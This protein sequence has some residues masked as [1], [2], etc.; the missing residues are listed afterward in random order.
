MNTLFVFSPMPVYP[1]KQGNRIRLY[2]TLK[3]FIDQGYRITFFCNNLEDSGHIDDLSIAMHNKLFHKFIYT[4]YQGNHFKT[5]ALGNQSEDE[6]WDSTVVELLKKEISLENF[7]ICITNYSLF[8]KVF[9]YFPK[10]THKI[11]EMHDRLG[12]RAELVNSNGIISDFF[13]TNIEREIKYLER[14]DTVICIKDAE[15]KY[16]KNNGFTKNAVTGYCPLEDHDAF[17]LNEDYLYHNKSLGFIGSDNRVNRQCISSIYRSINKN[18]EFIQKN[19][20]KI[21]I[22]GKISKFAESILPTE[23]SKNIEILG[24]IDEISDFYKK[25]SIL[26]NPT[27]FS[28]GFKLKNVESFSFGVPLVSTQDASDG[29]PNPPTFLKNK[30]PEATIVCAIKYLETSQTYSNL[31]KNTLAI[32]NKYRAIVESSWEKI[33]QIVSARNVC[34]SIAQELDTNY[35]LIICQILSDYIK[36]TDKILITDK[37]FNKI[38]FNYLKFNNFIVRTVKFESLTDIDLSLSINSVQKPNARL[39]I[40]KKSVTISPEV[41]DKIYLNITTNDINDAG[42]TV[43]VNDVRPYYIRQFNTYNSKK[44]VIYFKTNNISIDLNL[45]KLYKEIIGDDL[46]IIDKD[47]TFTQVNYILQGI[48]NR[49]I[50]IDF[51]DIKN[52]QI[53]KNYF[54][55]FFEPTLIT[56]RI[57]NV[58][59]LK[60]IQGPEINFINCPNEFDSKQI[61]K[62]LMNSN[63]AYAKLM[64]WSPYRAFAG[65]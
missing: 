23:I 11:V 54:Y 42:G 35:T 3:G 24:E 26:V 8:T 22:G 15:E 53:I 61:I 50:L 13:S 48:N 39:L 5:N 63:R 33:Y 30:T 43:V 18:L 27:A 2:Q 38:I 41:K 1:L 7:D 14:A 17:L 28:T 56:N 47:I 44:T 32:K 4:K 49:Y 29:I 64:L 37:F 25:I 9:E 16:L 34:L 46:I 6:V 21:K 12:G 57:D 20:I 62:D 65:Y 51:S 55:N 31:Y 19:H 58:N 52:H 45:I 40:G 60:K 10:S 36:K 59:L